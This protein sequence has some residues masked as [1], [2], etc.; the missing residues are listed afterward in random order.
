M[1]NKR[2]KKV[3][4]PKENR[5]PKEDRVIKKHKEEKKIIDWTEE[6]KKAEKDLLDNSK[7]IESSYK[8]TAS[9][10]KSDYRLKQK[11]NNGVIS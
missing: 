6:I 11:R 3:R 5:K 7:I 4:N 10:R 2:I 9:G 8:G 1:K